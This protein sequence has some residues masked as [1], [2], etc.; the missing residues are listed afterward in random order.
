M[1]AAEL[2]QQLAAWQP[3]ASEACRL[4]LLDE[5][6]RPQWSALLERLPEQPVGYALSHGDYQHE[7]FAS[8]FPRYRRL[9]CLIFLHEELVGLWP[10]GIFGDAGKLRLS[11]HINGAMGV[12]PPL[13]R[14]ALSEKQE[15]T[16][17][18]AWLG[19]IAEL[20]QDFSLAQVDFLAPPTSET[21]PRWHGQVMALG[22]SFGGQ[23]RLVADLALPE[24][25][26]H[27]HLRKS[28]KALLNH[29]A[30]LWR[31]ELDTVGDGEKF[32]GFR[33]LHE[34][35][36]GRKTR[37]QA[38]WQRQFEAIQA[39]AAFALYLYDDAGEMV[40]ASLFNCSRDEA[41]YAVGAYRR[42]LFDQ[43]LAHLNV[44]EAIRHARQRGLRRFILGQR[45]YPG[46]LPPPNEKEEQIAFFKEGFATGL[47]VQP[48]LQ[49][50]GNCL[51]GLM[52]TKTLD[53]FSAKP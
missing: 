7:Y 53:Y 52:S 38:T 3:P 48:L 44:Y 49:L 13:L 45:A 22:A 1:E 34:Q 5:S 8:A 27:R 12:A 46:D 19:M 24:A 50:A 6:N 39:G 9:D 28:Y 29:A 18:R 33:R 2:A 10:L 20:C 47:Q 26:Y 36:A 42:E 14:E 43:P 15:K 25:E 16:V 17:N 21:L 37:P 23:H 4:V 35:V 51:A 40:G 32:A 41:Y 31:V 11:S 30:K